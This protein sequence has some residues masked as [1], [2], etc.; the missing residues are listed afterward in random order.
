M[1]QDVY[2]GTEM[3]C[4]VDLPGRGVEVLRFDASKPESL[5]SHLNAGKKPAMV[6]CE[7]ISNPLVKVAKMSAIAKICEEAGAKL[8]VDAT[9]SAGIASQPL[10]QG[11]DVVVHS[12]T[13]YINGHSDVIAGAA[14]GSGQDIEAMYGFMVRY[15]CCIDPM[16]AWLIARGL[17]TLTLRFE[18]QC[19]TALGLAQRLSEHPGVLRVNYPGAAGNEFDE[20]NCG[21]GLL[22]FELADGDRAHAFANG[23]Q[24]CS[25][26]V[27]LGGVETLV[28]LPRESSHVGKT[29][30]HWESVG[31]GAGLVRVA[32]GL[33]DLDD[34]WV[35]MF[36][37][38]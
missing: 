16:G 9:F 7:S 13:K 14:V 27:S 35:D 25:H 3:I 29:P 10:A 22:S 5:K 6:F 36:A 18:R 38:L 24:L 17:R 37:A 34:I 28:D 15:G 26:A 33:E 4:E 31:I 8:V 20:L 21:G 23:V 2:G 32:L 12:A 30:G 1:S 19:T 11:A